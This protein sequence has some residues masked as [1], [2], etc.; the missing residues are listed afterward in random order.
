MLT[1]VPTP[2]PTPTSTGVV[3]VPGPGLDLPGR[4]GPFRDPVSR[5]APGV[6]VTRGGRYPSR[7]GRVVPVTGHVS[8]VNVPPCNDPLVSSPWAED[9]L[10]G[11]RGRRGQTPCPVVR[12]Q[13]T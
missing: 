10:R 2:T 1:R 12:S 5:T 3:S 9:L 13:S 4:S 11:T 6:S 8:L 7:T